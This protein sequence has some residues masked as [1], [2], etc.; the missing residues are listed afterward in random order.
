MVA[1]PNCP[2][3]EISR[4]AGDF[5]EYLEVEK[6]A[7]PL[8]IRN[9]RH[10]L[11]RF[12]QWMQKENIRQNLSD[13]NLEIVRQYRVYLTRLP[14]GKPVYK[15]QGTLTRKTQS[16]HIIA[17]RSFLK[18]LI[19]TDHQVMAPEKIDLPR[20]AERQIK[21]LTGDQVD[22]LLNAPSLSNLNGKRDK[23]ILE[24]LFSTGLRV[25]ELT[26]LDRDKV[27]LERR[28]FGIIGKG[29]KARVAFLSSR[30]AE[31]IQKYLASREDKYR[32][33]FIRHRGKID[34]STP[35]EKM[36]LTPRSVQRLLKKY[37]RKIKLPLEAS[38]HTLRHCLHSETRIFL[39]N[40]IVSARQLYYI[41]ANE[42][43]GL[44]FKKTTLIDAKIVGKNQ[45]ITDLYSIWADGYELVCSKEHRLF[46]LNVEGVIEIKAQ[47]LKVGDYILGVKKVNY[48]GINYIEPEVARLIGYILGDGVISKTRRGVIINDKDK[49]NLK[50]YAD[51]VKKYLKINCR[52]EKASRSNSYRLNLY[53]DQ[54]VDFLHEMGI[55]G[56]SNQR[57]IPEQ[58]M[59]SSKQEAVA[60]IAGVYDAEGNSNG[61]PRIF[62]TSKEF[63]KD[64]Q[65]M[66]L[67]FGIDA[68]LLVKDRAVMLPQG[69]MFQHKLFTL[70]ILD[71]VSQ[72]IFIKNVKTR[73]IKGLKN[74]LN[75]VDER[76]P[77]QTIL[78]AIFNDLEK[79]GKRGYRYALQ[80]N[81][82]IK[83]NRYLE[84]MLPT[85]STLLKYL[86]QF[87]RF[88][89]SGKKLEILKLVY[90][91]DNYKWL[92]VKKIKRLPS[93]R[94]SVFDFTV[95]PTQNLITDGI[96]SHNSFATDLLMAGADIRS[97]QE[98]LGHKNIQT[99]QIYT[100]VT[101]QHLKEIHDHFHGKG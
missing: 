69:R 74:I 48:A 25:S 27:D 3:T 2:V 14:A 94:Y 34:P 44:D 70:Q 43:L 47:N 84:K 50:F 86:R 51:I 88:K 75:G 29:G 41:K 1:L 6:G 35:D 18:W 46:T 31:W 87:E 81:E 77:V 4:L 16:Y 5:L 17:L 62:S 38:P 97:V 22:R 95:S 63:L 96:V 73:K 23:A 60:F 64:I 37:S 91:A 79:N 39:K 24:V 15:D 80:V 83:S 101:H 20:I 72:R 30:A 42:I 45:H 56:H 78:K 32:P 90:H 76:L 98:M 13:I 54:F 100:H 58:I 57:R 53:S 59:N 26:K 67:R 10:Y 36:R 55:S 99:T 19:K 21:F 93:P 65:M 71:K 61:D 82:N 89:Y 11:S 7:S 68:H 85:R 52:I 49:R 92:R 40:K 12:C 9:Y 33:L 8:T 28:E 66:F